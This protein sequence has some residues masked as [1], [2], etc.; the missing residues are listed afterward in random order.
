SL[1]LD[2]MTSA[3]ILES[4]QNEPKL[5]LNL[6]KYYAMLHK[7]KSAFDFDEHDEYSTSKGISGNYYKLFRIIKTIRDKN[8]QIP[9]EYASDLS[10]LLYKILEKAIPSKT[11]YKLL[12]ELNKLG[13]NI[14]DLT[15]VMNI[16]KSNIDDNLLQS[17]LS[18]KKVQGNEKKEIILSVYLKK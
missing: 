15:Q 10:N 6:D 8:E 11:V 17:H 12:K 16:L 4:Q 7:N 18:E 13:N 9:N 2:F 3:S 5:S 1:E 14:F